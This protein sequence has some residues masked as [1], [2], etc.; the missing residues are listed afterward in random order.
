MLRVLSELLFTLRRGGLA[1]SE[2]QAIDAARTMALVGFSDRMRLRWALEGVLVT[3]AADRAAFA[4][5]FDLAFS[6]DAG[7][8]GDLFDRL[9]G[10]GFSA[11]EI[12]AVREILSAA[13]Q[14]S[15]SAAE[16]AGL[17]LL[18][19][20]AYDLDWLLRGARMQRTLGGLASEKTV[21]YFS[22]RAGRSLGLD[23]AASAIDRL[24]AAFRETAGADR[25]AELAAALREEVDAIRGRIRASLVERVDAT[26]ALEGTPKSTLD[27]PFGELA[28]D[29]RADVE[30]A[31]RLLSEKLRGGAMVR[32]RHRRRGRV[33]VRRT[34][35]AAAAT[36]GTPLSIRFVRPRPHRIKLVLVCDISDSVR[37][38]SRFLLQLVA[39]TSDLFESVRSFVFVGDVME[40]TDMFARGR[41]AAL[42]TGPER[43]AVELGAASDYQRTF[44]KL[45]RALFPVLDRR[46]VFVVLGDGRTN[47]RPDGAEVL[48]RM[49]A[50]TRA[51]LWLCPEAPA[52]W[53]L[54]DSRM[55]R[56]REVCTTVL[57]ART[58]RELEEAARKLARLR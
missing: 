4:R 46:T 24:V 9:R 17:R 31:V 16:G 2:S 49:R 14:R 29:E 21:G 44:V 19:S 36:L 26:R 37:S 3:R 57:S 6:A 40:T 15:G 53:G 1:I 22:Q 33:D 38:A 11:V 55:N 43:M 50:R 48:E 7:H 32:R 34:M 18:G 39:A 30:R 5:G 35:R 58:A 8:P 47:N 23:R 20:G 45:E 52:Q 42:D 13:A 27:V 12:D 28:R 51:V 56:Y 54:G 41:R 25:A 10:R